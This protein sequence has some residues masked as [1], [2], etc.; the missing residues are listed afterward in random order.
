[1]PIATE[2]PR[3]T[4]SKIEWTEI[5]WNPVT[6]CTKI[7]EGCKFCYAAAIAARRWEGRKFSDIRCHPDR[8]EVPLKT[9]RP[10]FIFV[11]SMSDLYHSDVPD[12]F[13][14]RVFDVMEKADQHVY[15]ILTK[16]GASQRGQRLVEFWA[17]RYPTDAPAHIWQGVS[18]ENQEQL[19]F[20]VPLLKQISAPLKWISFEPLLEEVDFFPMGGDGKIK[21]GVIGGESGYANRVREFHLEWAEKLIAQLRQ[22]DVAPFMKQVGK[23]AWYK[24]QKIRI[25]APMGGDM[26][27][28]LSPS[29]RVREYPDLPEKGRGPNEEVLFH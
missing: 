22:F 17:K 25:L 18:V 2:L 13:L 10:T 5:T 26:A 11:N 6:G 8:L 1:M 3:Q 7:S 12:D 23:N 4:K 29:I 14:N 24:G 9:R 20:R 27:E 16:H 21:W 15:Q 19:L 28:W